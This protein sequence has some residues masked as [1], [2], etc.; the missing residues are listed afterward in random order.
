M[1]KPILSRLYGIPD[2]NNPYTPKELDPVKDPAQLDLLV[3]SGPFAVIDEVEAYL[4][5]CL[6]QG[7]TA[8]F[9]VTGESGTGRSSVARAIIAMHREKLFSNHPGEKQT[10]FFRPEMPLPHEDP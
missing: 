7:T 8:F 6:A 10:R 4:E 5:Q 1:D 2:G 3:R 9:L